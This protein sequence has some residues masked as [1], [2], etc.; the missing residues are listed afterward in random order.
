MTR[1]VALLNSPRT[2]AICEAMIV[3]PT[4]MLADCEARLT[5]TVLDRES[6]LLQMGRAEALREVKDQLQALFGRA[7]RT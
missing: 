6:Y 1:P 3:V 5:R 4:A 2:E 7:F